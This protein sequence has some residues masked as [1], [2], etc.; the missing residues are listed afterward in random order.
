[1]YAHA[2]LTLFT[3]NRKFNRCDRIPIWLKQKKSRN[4]KAWAK[5]FI[6]EEIP[7]TITVTRATWMLSA[8]FPMRLHFECTLFR[9][10]RTSDHTASASVKCSGVSA[11]RKRYYNGEKQIFFLLAISSFIAIPKPLVLLYSKEIALEISLLLLPKADG[12]SFYLSLCHPARITNEYWLSP[13]MCNDNNSIQ[14][15]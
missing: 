11:G 4:K 9:T 6:N 2:T 13:T 10:Q 14:L 8:N 1:M 12:I 15:N 3:E 5:K 7:F